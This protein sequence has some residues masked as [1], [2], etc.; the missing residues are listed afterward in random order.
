MLFG[1]G[2][3]DKK[4]YITLKNGHSFDDIR[5]IAVTILSGDEVLDIHFNNDYDY[6]HVDCGTGR[7]HNYYDGSYIV[8]PED[9]PKW[10]ERKSSYDCKFW[11]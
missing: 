6:Q 10:L 5:F 3:D 8:D 11:N 7:I 4:V 2:Y 9:I 1:Y